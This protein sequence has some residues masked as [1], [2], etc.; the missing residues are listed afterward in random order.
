[1]S[2]FATILFFGVATGRP[3][4]RIVLSNS[5]PPLIDHGWHILTKRWAWFFLVM[6]VLNEII[7]RNMSTDNWVAAKLFVFLPLS[8]IF[9]A[10]QMP[11]IERYQ[12]KPEASSETAGE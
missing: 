8:V 5:F 12:P 1:Y 6:A 2:L 4:L 10:C 9:A 3:Y 11:L 7:W